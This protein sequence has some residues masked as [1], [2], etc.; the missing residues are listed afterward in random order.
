[1][2]ITDVLNTFEPGDSWNAWRQVA[3]VLDG[4]PVGDETLWRSIAGARMPS[5]PSELYAAVGRGGGKSEFAAI[6]AAAYA[7]RTYKRSWLAPRIAII[8]IAPNQKQASETFVYVQQVFQHPKFA[9]F[10]SSQTETTI[11]LKNHVR[12]SVLPANAKH[13]RS[14]SSALV[15]I[16]EAAFLDKQEYSAQPDVELVRA[17]RPS[18]GRV[19]GSLLMVV[20]SKFDRRG[21]LYDASAFFGKDGDTLYVEGDTQTFNPTFDLRVIEKAYRDDP[22]AAASEYGTAWRADVSGFFTREALTAVT[23]AGRREL[24][25]VPGVSYRAFLDF[26]GGS[27]GDSAACAVAFTAN[28]K[29]ILAAYREIKPPFSPDAACREFAEFL[30]SYRVS[31]AKADH[32]GGDFP[33]ER[34]TTYGVRVEKVAASESK[35]HLYGSL[36]PLINSGLVELLDTE[37]LFV[38]IMSLERR[39]DKIDAFR[40]HEDVANAVAGA[41]V[42]SRNAGTGFRIWGGGSDPVR[43]AAKAERVRAEARRILFEDL[44]REPTTE[45]L[46]AKPEAAR[47]KGIY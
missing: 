42:L 28:G 25:P 12:L 3:A 45:E 31:Q 2:T 43:E 41:L 21:I 35:S 4:Q 37:R 19:P 13:V 40:G 32:W 36:L 29:E 6:V 16:E 9:P 20:S 34:M 1:M 11:D 10:V 26:A 17:I 24:P 15:I 7:T 38:Q 14:R 23:I 22:V 47:A 46:E 5:I 30:K 33:A 18:L 27:G 8:V 44:K 39:G